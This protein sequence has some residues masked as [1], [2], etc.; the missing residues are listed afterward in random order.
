[1]LPIETVEDLL[2]DI[3][4]E[5]PD[6]FFRDLNGG[7]ILQADVKMNPQARN[8]DLY[9]LG[10]YRR[11]GW[12]GRSIVIYYG[13]LAVV[14]GWISAEQLKEKLIALLKHEFRHH[15]EALAGSRDLELADEQFLADY[16]RKHKA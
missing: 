3:L 1:M 10:E 8:N 9:I 12:L 14:Y 4:A 2:G 11:D 7:V 6:L 5:F 13:S 16:F 15:L